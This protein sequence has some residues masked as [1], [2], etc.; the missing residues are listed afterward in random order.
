MELL[1]Q[2]INLSLHGFI[3]ISFVGDM[4]FPLKTA[5]TW[6]DGMHIA[7]LIVFLIS[8]TF[9]IEEIILLMNIRRFRLTRT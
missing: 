7:F 2:I 1:F 9:K 6:M 8:F 3:I 5:S 4:A